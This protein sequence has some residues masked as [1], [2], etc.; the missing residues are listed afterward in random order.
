MGCVPMLFVAVFFTVVALSD[1]AHAQ[2]K[3][4]AT[5]NG[6]AIT[7]DQVRLGEIEW[8][9]QLADLPPEARRRAA[10]GLLIENELVAKAAT[11]Q[12]LLSK[13]QQAT[14]EKFASALALR[15]Y[16]LEKKISDQINDTAVKSFYDQQIGLLP[17]I[18]EFHARHVLVES[19]ERALEIKKLAEGGDFAA[20]ARQFSRD[21]TTNLL[22]GDLGYFVKGQ[23]LPEIEQAAI[24]LRIGQVSEPVQT[25]SGWHLVRME[26]RRMRSLP[27]FDDLKDRLKSEL[28]QRK[29]QEIIAALLATAK[30]QILD[31]VPGAEPAKSNAK[32]AGDAPAA[33]PVGSRWAQGGSFMQL[34]S[35]GAK[36]EF[37]FETLT[38]ELASQGVKP[39]TLMFE[40]KKDGNRY[41]GMAYAFAKD[42]KPKAYAVTGDISG[43]EK[44]ITLRGKAPRLDG[45][46]RVNGEK[47]DEIVFVFQMPS[48]GQ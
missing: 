29:A 14:L 2:D 10:I 38:D 44:Q 36:R 39:G 7:E 21:P 48:G 43:D 24:S 42:C 26:D 3:T 18:E 46:C 5:V 13:S 33:V 8:A 15:S 34:R 32:A 11:D 23:M 19:R 1:R 30:I 37:Y 40:G 27:A 6:N 31:D 17:P 47:E 25:Q 9:N 22:G 4:V 35:N 16:Y 28:R 45:R 12:K 20:L 41:V